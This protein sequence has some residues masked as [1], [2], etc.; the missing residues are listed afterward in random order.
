M[1]KSMLYERRQNMS[2]QNTAILCFWPDSSAKSM[3]QGRC[4]RYKALG[5][6]FQ[7]HRVFRLRM[8]SNKARGN[9]IN[10][11]VNPP[12][13][14]A[15]L[16]HS[17]SEHLTSWFLG[18]WLVPLLPV[19]Y[20]KCHT[21]VHRVFNSCLDAQ[22]KIHLNIW[23]WYSCNLFY[24]SR[25]AEKIQVDVECNIHREWV[26]LDKWLM[27]NPRNWIDLYSRNNKPDM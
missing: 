22:Y 16:F 8:Y 20:S 5:D 26:S 9:P 21:K 27:I 13:F 12:V 19:K 24:H 6:L 14:G 1:L 7:W 2:K 10:L 11:D 4:S 23:K 18:F 3:H 15:S 17:T 25:Y